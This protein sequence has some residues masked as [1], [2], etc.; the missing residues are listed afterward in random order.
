MANYCGNCG[1]EV[2]KDVTICPHCG[3]P[4]KQAKPK[5]EFDGGVLEWIG[6]VLLMGFLCGITLGIGLPWALCSFAK[7]IAEHTVINGQRLKFTGS[8]GGLFGNWIKWLLLTLVTLGIY[9]LWVPVKVVKW[10]V[11]HLTYNN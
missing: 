8:G 1:K 2:D 3:V 7:W 4:V 5:S 9:G 11:S 10:V 6:H